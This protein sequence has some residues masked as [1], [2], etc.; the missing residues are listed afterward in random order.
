MSSLRSDMYAI[1]FMSYVLIDDP[2]EIRG[3]NQDHLRRRP[4]SEWEVARNIMSCTFIFIIQMTLVGF[5]LFN[6]NADKKSACR[7]LV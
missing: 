1:T 6:L 2:R 5:A 7:D 3:V 4:I